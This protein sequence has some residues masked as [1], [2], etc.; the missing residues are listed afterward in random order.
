MEI[1]TI[2]GNQGFEKEV[3]APSSK[4]FSHRYILGAFFCGKKVKVSNIIYSKD[5]LATLGA[6]EAMGAI[7]EKGNDYVYIFF[8][9][10]NY[11]KE[12]VE[13]DCNESASTL[14]FIIPIAAA[15]GIKCKI[16][17]RKSLMDRPLD[18]Y[19]KLF[20]EAQIDY[21]YKKGE[22][23]KINGK[24]LG[25]EYEIDGN[26]SS[27]FIT[28]LLF[29]LSVCD[30]KSILKI[31]K[32]LESKPYVDI[33]LGVLEFFGVNIKNNDY[34]SFEIEENSTYI[35]KDVT[36]EGDYSQGCAFIGAALLGGKVKINNLFKNSLQGDKK[37]I[38]FM[39]SLGANIK[40]YEDYI[41]CEKS[42]LIS[43]KTFDVSHCPDI[44]PV[45]SAVCAFSEGKTEIVGIKR[46]RIKESD[47]V[48]SIIDT[49]KGF[50]IDAF[51]TEEKIIINGKH[52]ACGGT[53]DTFNDHRIAMMIS[54]MSTRCDDE[55]SLK[56]PM[57]VEKS[58]P[59][60]YED[61][62][63]IITKKQE[64]KQ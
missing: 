5:T 1:L 60:F 31:N 10:K 34:E 55:I 4:S 24:L 21:E 11:N 49:L 48:K 15:L 57:C 41:E 45:L 7:V 59:S 53:F 42:N 43:G 32:T 61:F 33:T 46:L 22:Y 3:M 64:K 63:G 25:G 40:I 27:Q 16:F 36:V 58:Y 13:I 17:G 54:V 35:P 20:D 23:I 47:R 37:F 52:K 6:I 8:D 28:G 50:G 30:K 38:D 26:I 56:T 14:R 51:S 9:R 39:L 29:A 44:T 62:E 19:I 12:N 18:V 2:K